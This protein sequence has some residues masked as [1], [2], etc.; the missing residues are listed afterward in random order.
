M[1]EREYEIDLRELFGIIKKRFWAIMLITVISVGASALVSH[2]ILT[3][4][5][6][7]STT[8]IVVK[9]NE[10]DMAIQYN[11]IILSQ[12]LVKTYG[13]IVKSR[14]VAKKVIENLDLSIPPEKLVDKI[15]VSPVKDTEIISIKVADTDPVLARKIANELAVVFVADIIKIMNVDNVQVID[16]AETPKNPIRPKPL[17]NMAIAG[18]IGL[19]IGLGLVFLMEFMDNT[20]KTSDDIEKHL[21]LPVL[22]MIPYSKEHTVKE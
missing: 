4:V 3:P 19:M 5:Y 18:V 17:L 21:K 12:K 9:S 16:P 10:S 1:E 22:G 2:F 13:E 7:T 14:T 6:E 11:D 8:L 20:I 15:I